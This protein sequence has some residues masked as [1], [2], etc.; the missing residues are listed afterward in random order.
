M[1][2]GKVLTIEVIN[3]LKATLQFLSIPFSNCY[4]SFNF[5]GVRWLFDAKL[6]IAS[7]SMWLKANYPEVLLHLSSIT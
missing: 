3:V 5:N 1:Y 6:N 4:D 2:D 7:S